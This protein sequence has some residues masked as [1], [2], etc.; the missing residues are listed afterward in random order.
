MALDSKIAELAQE[1]KGLTKAVDQLL[2]WQKEDHD[3]V[4][5]LIEKTGQL[6]SG[7]KEGKSQSFQWGFMMVSAL[8][9]MILGV[10]A[11]IVVARLTKGG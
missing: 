4:V 1:V 3:K 11:A 5:I 6:E 9:S 7:Q 10:V 2:E 8:I